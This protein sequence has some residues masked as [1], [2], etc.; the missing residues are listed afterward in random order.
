MHPQDISATEITTPSSSPFLPLLS[1]FFHCTFLVDFL[2]RGREGGGGR[3]VSHF[4]SPVARRRP[5]MCS[6]VL[7]SRLFVRLA[8]IF[9]VIKRGSE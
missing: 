1:F 6:A 2:W 7:I 5:L 3:K 8:S 9:G 4:G